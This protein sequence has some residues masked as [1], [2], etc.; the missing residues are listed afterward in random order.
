MTVPNCNCFILIKNSKVSQHL[1]TENSWRIFCRVTVSLIDCGFI[2][3]SRS[4]AGFQFRIG[5]WVVQIVW[6]K[7]LN[8]KT[9][10]PWYL[11]MKT[12]KNAKIPLIIGRL[13]WIWWKISWIM[14]MFWITLVRGGPGLHRNY[15][16]FFNR[17]W[18]GSVV[19][20]V[21]EWS[22]DHVFH[23]H[24]NLGGIHGHLIAV[25]I[26]YWPGG[27]GHYD[28]SLCNR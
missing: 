1:N 11:M 5:I 3:N 18:Q 20:A 7:R 16:Y 9:L 17:F 2:N 22:Y 26:W 4:W 15:V 23:G 28:S 10:A 14:R 25:W 6:L 24:S 12:L 19:N 13:S 21:D 8:L 27:K